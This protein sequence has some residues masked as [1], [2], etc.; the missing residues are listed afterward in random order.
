[1]PVLSSYPNQ[2]FQEKTEQCYR[3]ISLINIDAKNPRQ[4]A[5]TSNPTMEK[6]N[7]TKVACILGTPGWVNIQKQINVLFHINRS[8]KI[9]HLIIDIDTNILCKLE[10]KGIP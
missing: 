6:K 8:K 10:I 9:N 2:T 1:M 4:S 5:N 7:T 3:T